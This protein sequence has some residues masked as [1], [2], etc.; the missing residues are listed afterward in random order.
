MTALDPNLLR[1]AK[2]SKR[3][4]TVLMS[5]MLVFK[6]LSSMITALTRET[7]LIV[8]VLINHFVTDTR[9]ETLE[10]VMI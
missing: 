7:T 4:S 6:H 5:L 2:V 1:I 8:D 10:I 9:K 3:W